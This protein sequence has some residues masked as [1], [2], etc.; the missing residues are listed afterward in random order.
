MKALVFTI[1]TLFIAGNVF[2]ESGTCSGKT[3]NGKAVS[4]K[5]FTNGYSDDNIDYY[6]KIKVGNSPEVTYAL[7]GT[8]AGLEG[9]PTSKSKRRGLDLGK[10][11][12]KMP[13]NKKSLSG[14]IG[15]DE[16]KNIPCS[17]AR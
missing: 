1:A 11:E 8:T 15:Q 9:E 5:Y 14:S 3:T 13:A 7:Y 6:G 16:I 10:A 17:Y 4:V 12:F 2:A